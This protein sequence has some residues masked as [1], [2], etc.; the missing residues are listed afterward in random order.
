MG[1]VQI[2]GETDFKFDKVYCASGTGTT[3]SG[4]MIGSK[5]SMVHAVNVLKGI[6]DQEIRR[7]LYQVLM[8]E[9]A[10]EELLQEH[11]VNEQHHF[12][13]YAKWN[14]DLISLMQGFYRQ[15]GIKTDPIYTG[16]VLSAICEDVQKSVVNEAHRILMIHTG[17]LQGIHGFEKKSGC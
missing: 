6:G 9:S 15:T 2:L 13:G 7:R 11:I 12:G 1:C 10:V 3:V 5:G 14:D 4:L 17:G 16:K 8:D